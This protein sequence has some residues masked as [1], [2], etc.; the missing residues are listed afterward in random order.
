MALDTITAEA[1]GPSAARRASR[2]GQLVTRG[3][4]QCV[5]CRSAAKL[6]PR[7][8]VCAVEVVR[9]SRRVHEARLQAALLARTRALGS[10]SA[11]ARAPAAP[12]P[13]WQGALP[14]TLA[15]R[16]CE[17]RLALHAM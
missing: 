12:A 5:L 8:R 7:V 13:R 14:P 4:H 9:A 2:Q 3:S 1:V 17:Q 16:E 11:A 10:A 15:R 6:R